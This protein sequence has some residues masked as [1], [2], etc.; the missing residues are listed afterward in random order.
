MK[1]IKHTTDYQ[2]RAE[3]TYQA[4]EGEVITNEQLEERLWPFGGYI[5]YNNGNEAKIT[6]YLD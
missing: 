1:V 2:Y 4:D 6:K 3:Y 5:N